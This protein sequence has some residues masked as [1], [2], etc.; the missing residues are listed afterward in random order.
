MGGLGG[1]SRCTCEAMGD[2]QVVTG[3]GEGMGSGQVKWS[4]VEWSGQVITCTCEGMGSG[5]VRW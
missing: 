5:Q 3:T 2:V 4:R 1:G